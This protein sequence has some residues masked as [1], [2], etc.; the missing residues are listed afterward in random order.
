MSLKIISPE[1]NRLEGI[2]KQRGPPI[3][4]MVY[5]V[6]AGHLAISK[7]KIEERVENQKRFH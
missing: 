7:P 2:I 6:E 1:E 3:R 4:G 5:I